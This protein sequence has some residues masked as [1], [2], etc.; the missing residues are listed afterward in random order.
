VLQAEK[1]ALSHFD[2]SPLSDRR[3]RSCSRIERNGYAHDATISATEQAMSARKYVNFWP[4]V[5]LSGLKPPGENWTDHQNHGSGKSYTCL[6]TKA[7][8]HRCRAA[9]NSATA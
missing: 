1:A 2:F 8:P 4:T 6:K 9:R 7:A 3:W 5:G